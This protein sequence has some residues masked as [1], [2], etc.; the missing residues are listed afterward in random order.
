MVKV[1]NK[2]T[3]AFF[4]KTY[5]SIIQKNIILICFCDKMNVVKYFKLLFNF[6]YKIV[7]ERCSID[8]F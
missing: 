8:D 2:Y 3:F 6:K 5:V 4:C 1:F 7:N